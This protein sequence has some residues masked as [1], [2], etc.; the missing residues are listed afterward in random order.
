MAIEL[1][2]CQKDAADEFVRHGG[3]LLLQSDVGHGKTFFACECIRRSI[4]KY[5]APALYLSTK[6]ALKE[7]ASKFK[8]FGLEGKVT[9]GILEDLSGAKWEEIRNVP[10]GIIVI[11]EADRLTG[12]ASKRNRRLLTLRPRHRLLMTGTIL[13]NGLRDAF[14]PVMWLKD[15][16]PWRNWTDFSMR[17]LR[18]DNPNVPNQVTGIRDEEF[19]ASL[20]QPLL[21]VMVNPDAPKELVPEEV[22]VILSSE[23]RKAYEEMVETSILETSRG[24]MLISNQAVL[25]LRC[26]QIVQMPEAL[27]VGIPSS[28]EAALLAKMAENRGKSIVFTSFAS[29]A[30]ILAARHGWTLIEGSMTQKRRAEAL[31]SNPEVIVATSAAERGIDLPEL[32]FVHCLDRGFTSATVRQR[33]GRATRYGRKGEARLFLYVAPD[34]VDIRSEERIVLRKLKQARKVCQENHR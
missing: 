30:R 17:E 18:H 25:N 7:Q 32:K 3:R 4:E 9:M 22:T 13:R 23:H 31:A 14:L 1:L 27:G 21:H 19:L 5:P 20:L 15:D 29:V 10:W 2:K 11:D 6:T 28:K 12:S 8:E 34:T 33:A 16:P 24:T 26:R